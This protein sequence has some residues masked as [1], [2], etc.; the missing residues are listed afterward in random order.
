MPKEN[1]MQKEM[2][3]MSVLS[4]LIPAVLL[5]GALVY[6]AFCATGY[7]IF[8]KVVIVIIALIV[9][10]V[11]EALLWMVWAGKRGLMKWP[12]PK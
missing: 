6:V 9:V 7:S 4:I 2:V 5:I 12:E 8:Q 3:C 1:A 10:G 11:A